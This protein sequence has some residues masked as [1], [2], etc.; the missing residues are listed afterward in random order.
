[1]GDLGA[2]ADAGARVEKR[3]ERREPQTRVVD[4]ARVPLE[5]LDGRLDE[6]GRGADLLGSRVA[7]PELRLIGGLRRNTGEHDGAKGHGTAANHGCLHWPGNLRERSRTTMSA[8]RTECVRPVR[9]WDASRSR[10]PTR[11][12]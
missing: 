8:R 6:R 1:V 4:L 3:I 11:E 7:E 10:C 9:R 2:M 5:E 12:R